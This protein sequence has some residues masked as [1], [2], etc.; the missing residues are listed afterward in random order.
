MD[1][2]RPSA[3][4]LYETYY[5]ER[6]ARR[7]SGLFDPV[8]SFARRQKAHRLVRAMTKGARILDVGCER[9]ELLHVLEGLGCSVRGT[10][11]SQAAADHAWKRFG[12][13]VYVGELP[14]AAFPPGSFDGI[15][16]IN[17]LEHLPS[18]GPY[19][20][21]VHRLLADGGVFWVEVPNSESFTARM[22]GK[23][24]L[25]AD[26]E[27]HFWGFGVGPLRRLLRGHGFEVEQVHHWS[28]EHGPI[29]CVQSWLNLLPGPRNVVFDIVV[30][31]IDR[32]RWRTQLVHVL[33]AALLLPVGALVAALEAASGRGQ[34]VLVLARKPKESQ[35]IPATVASNATPLP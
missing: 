9:G 29:G 16:M 27:H 19:V 10:Q 34:V 26:P 3:A 6:A 25:H 35:A 8:W 7:V 18:P 5:T 14:D 2:P 31:G 4:E 12:I 13:E 30:N 23:R 1:M 11:I 28:W 24:W 32:R 33:L 17:V 21:E 15:L 20:A 22:T